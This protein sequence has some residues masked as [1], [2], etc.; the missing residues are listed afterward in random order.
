MRFV[1]F[2]PNR[3]RAWCSGMFAIGLAGLPLAAG[4]SATTTGKA[5]FLYCLA[6]GGA[7]IFAGKT[8]ADGSLKFGVSVW[9]STGQNISVFGTAARVGSGWRF[10][11]DLRGDTPAERCRLDI[12]RGADGALRVTAD[13]DANCQAR[14]GVNAAIGAIEFPRT[15]YEGPVTT[16]L[17]NPEA[18]QKAVKCGRTEQ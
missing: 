1:L 2:P 8:M 6:N 11:E 7:K 16:E 5:G 9:S 14:G 3:K 10:T 13:P 15:T 18:F 17:D 12:A 4:G